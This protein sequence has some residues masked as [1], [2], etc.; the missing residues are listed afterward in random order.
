MLQSVFQGINTVYNF[1]TTAWDNVRHMFDDVNIVALW[2]SYVP[3]D[4]IQVL[5][6]LAALMILLCAIGLIKKI[7]VVFG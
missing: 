5:Q 7:L 4:I 3:S 2:T 1:L 6:I